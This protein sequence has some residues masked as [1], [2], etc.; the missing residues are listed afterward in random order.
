M[1][2][3]G[4]FSIHRHKIDEERLVKALLIS[5]QHEREPVRFRTAQLLSWM[6]HPSILNSLLKAYP[7]PSPRVQIYLIAALSQFDDPRSLNI[8]LEALKHSNDKISS[9]AA[10]GLSRSDNPQVIPAL[11]KAIKKGGVNT[12]GNAIFTLNMKGA[13]V[14]EIRV[15]A[16]HPVLHIESVLV[17]YKI[18]LTPNSPWQEVRW[19]Y[20]NEEGIELQLG[21]EFLRSDGVDHD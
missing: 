14:Q 19:E 11:L 12:R 18:Q 9:Q 10:A 4:I 6:A 7:D 20:Q 8:R 21:E 5:L 1:S 17:G 2:R 13:T 15:K 16:D 3:A